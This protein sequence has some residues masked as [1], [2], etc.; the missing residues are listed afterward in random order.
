MEFN[1]AEIT[2]EQKAAALANANTRTVAPLPEGYVRCTMIAKV[3]NEALVKA[4]FEDRTIPSQMVYTYAKKG[5]GGLK[6]DNYPHV[7][8]AVALEWI[9][10]Q[11]IVRTTLIEADVEDTEPETSDKL[12]EEP[13]S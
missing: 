8:E 5:T 7:P 10:K 6:T 4:G 2:D 3:L 11:F 9:R 1:P 12:V 13:T